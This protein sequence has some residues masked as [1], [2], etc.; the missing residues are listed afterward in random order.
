MTE[1]SKISAPFLPPDLRNSGNYIISLS[2]LCRWLGEE[3]ESMDVVLLPG[4]SASEPLINDDDDNKSMIGV[5]T[6]DLGL[7]KDGTMGPNFERGTE[8]IAR[9]TVLSEGCRG[10]ISEDVMNIFNLRNECDPQIYGIGFKEVW[11]IDSN[12]KNYMPGKVVHALGY[13]I[14]DDT[15]GGSFIYHCNDNQVLIGCVIGLEY[16]N[17]YLNPYMEFQVELKSY[18]E[19]FFIIIPLCFCL[20]IIYLYICWIHRN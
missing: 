2:D 18:R 3:A 8:V 12:N 6:S 15:Y 5:A 4:F 13:P 16:T 1:K 10:S 20:Y 17:P 7:L 9:Q 11:R 19:M 14:P